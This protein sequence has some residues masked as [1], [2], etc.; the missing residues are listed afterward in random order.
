MKAASLHELKQ[1]LTNLPASELIN[2]CVR[3]ARFKKENK[4]LLTY[5]LFEAFDETAYIGLVKAEIE[6]SFELVNT[7]NIYFAKKS[8]RKILRTVSKYIRYTGSHQAEVELLIYYCRKLKDSGISLTR[9]PVINNIY[10]AQLKKINKV[11]E[12]MHEDLQ[13]EYRRDLDYLD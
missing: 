2:I 9:Y 13:Y 1:E 5:L 7:S 11:L 3:L 6:E 8:L 4:E 12:T 10:Q